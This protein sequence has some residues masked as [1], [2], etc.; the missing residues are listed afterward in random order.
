VGKFVKRQLLYG[1]EVRIATAQHETSPSKR[2]GTA[3]QPAAITCSGVEY[4]GWP[5]K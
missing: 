1:K 5:K 4:T 3:V 2:I